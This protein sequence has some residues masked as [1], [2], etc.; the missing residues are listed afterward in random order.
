MLTH[1][2]VSRPLDDRRRGP[3][4]PGRG[5]PP[6]V[7]GDA[8]AA[9]AWAFAIRGAVA[10]GSAGVVVLLPGLGRLLLGQ[11]LVFQPFLGG[12][13]L[14]VALRRAPWGRG[15]WPHPFRSEALLGLLLGG[16]IGEFGYALKPAVLPAL[17]AGTAIS[18]VLWLK[19]ATRLAPRH[20]RYWAFCAGGVS[21]L[22][23]AA[24]AAAVLVALL[25]N[26][27]SPPGAVLSGAIGSVL[28]VWFP[29]FASLSGTVQ[30]GLAV[31]LAR[32]APAQPLRL[33]AE[34]FALAGGALAATLA[35][36]TSGHVALSGAVLLVLVLLPA[37]PRR[38]HRA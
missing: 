11:L 37:M 32:G 3:A 25:R 7:E 5:A 14:L 22:A 13:L 9:H 27:A 17:A 1:P 2:A 10:L 24:L 18:G 28:E 35:G 21:V 30:L 29:A 4:S 26:D 33:R 38:P 23:G 6:A 34:A 15:A 31:R 36:L 12:A 20:G 16:A 19:G 8:L